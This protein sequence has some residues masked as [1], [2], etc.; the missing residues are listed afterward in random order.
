M[1]SRTPPPKK[2]WIV[3]AGVAIGAVATT[4]TESVIIGKT[5]ADLFVTFM[6]S[7]A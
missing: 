2:R 7:L 4:L 3:I 6:S 5:L 1:T